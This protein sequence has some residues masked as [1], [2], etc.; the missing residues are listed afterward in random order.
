MAHPASGDAAQRML[1]GVGRPVQSKKE[2]E[3]DWKER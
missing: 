3:D 1:R 2:D